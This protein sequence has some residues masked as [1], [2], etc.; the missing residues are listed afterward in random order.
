MTDEL[1]DEDELIEEN[2]TVEDSIDIKIEPGPTLDARRR[3]EKMLEK[4]RLKNEL[5]DLA[6]YL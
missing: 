5:N 3:L 2:R 1:F 4:K 6:D